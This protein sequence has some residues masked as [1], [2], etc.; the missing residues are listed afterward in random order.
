MKRKEGFTLIELLIVIAIIALL[1]GILLPALS[2]AREQAK[3]AICASN[4]KQIGLAL[5]AY[6][7]D[8][9]D[10]L[11]FAGGK[12]PSYPKPFNTNTVEDTKD[13]GHPY[14][15]F[16]C[17]HTPAGKD[18]PWQVGGVPC[19]C[20]FSGAE[21]GRPIP[22][23]LGCLFARGY[24]GDGKAFY[25]PS[26]RDQTYQ[27][28][29]YI[30]PDPEI[31]GLSSAWGT[32]HQFFSKQTAN[33][34]IRVG[35]AYYPIDE[36]ITR[37][38]Q[39]ERVY[40]CWVPRYT[41]RRFSLI[42]KKTPVAT[43]ILWTREDISHKSGVDSNKNVKNGGLNALFKDGHVIFTRDQTVKVP[44]GF[45]ADGN[46]LFQNHYWTM[47]D[48]VGVPKPNELTDGDASRYLLY[49]IFMMIKP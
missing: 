22:M 26:N 17:K 42:S 16:R 39:M 6:V 18:T 4:L 37:P 1:M 48:P 31:S 14:V 19:V 12:D 35:Y 13:E 44:S 40:D 5:I 28:E 10:M 45:A 3:R 9:D 32:P 33:D 38:P 2:K 29:S 25:C 21:G 47:W 43:D 15:A 41:A 36:T 23:R 11:P 34:W 49:N 24:M 7:N 20:G 8:H 27:Y 46:K 30:K